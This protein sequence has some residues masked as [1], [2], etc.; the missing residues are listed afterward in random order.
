[1]LGAAIDRGVQ[2]AAA[3]R[4]DRKVRVHSSHLKG[5]VE[6]DLDRLAPW[7]GRG[8]GAIMCLGWRGRWRR[9]GAEFPSGDLIWR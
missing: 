2:V 8:R 3:R 5:V 9:T 7:D 1:V 4:S 6:S